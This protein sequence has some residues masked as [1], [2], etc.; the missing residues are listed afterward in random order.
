MF[1]NFAGYT[2]LQREPSAWHPVP[3]RVWLHVVF[4]AM[5]SGPLFLP[6]SRNIHPSSDICAFLCLLLLL[7]PLPS[8]CIPQ[9][10]HLLRANTYATSSMMPSTVF[11]VA[12]DLYD[13]CPPVVTA[14]FSHRIFSGKCVWNVFSSTV[15][16]HIASHRVG[17]E[18][19]CYKSPFVSLWKMLLNS[20]SMIFS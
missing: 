2:S 10:T 15:Y 9:S 19:R 12:I 6:L 3:F 4:L 8:L 17:W 13:L 1:R 18:H 11:L 20:Y 14:L 5:F 16:P 7:T